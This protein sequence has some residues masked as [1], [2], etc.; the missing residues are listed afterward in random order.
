MPGAAVPEPALACAGV[1]VCAAVLVF[2]AVLE[3]ASM[4]AGS[5]VG[6]GLAGVLEVT[7]S[8]LEWTDEP[9]LAT[10]VTATMATTALSTATMRRRGET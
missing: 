5:E 7:R 9:R 10:A 3:R 6:D 4:D 8:A 2:A 1:L